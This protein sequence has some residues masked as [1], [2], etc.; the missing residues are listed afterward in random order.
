MQMLL[1]NST[2]QSQ[3][4]QNTK[5]MKA[6]IALSR[7]TECDIKSKDHAIDQLQKKLNELK[8]QLFKEVIKL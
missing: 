7:A 6:A 8:S 3:L 5:R 4:H 1:I 2:F